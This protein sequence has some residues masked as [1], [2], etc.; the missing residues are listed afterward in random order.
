MIV[1]RPLFE[2]CLYPQSGWR[3]ELGAVQRSGSESA[4]QRG[5]GGDG[6]RVVGGLPQDNDPVRRTAH[7]GGRWCHEYLA[8]TSKV[9]SPRVCRPATLFFHERLCSLDRV[10]L[11][12]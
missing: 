11:T 3:G 9:E 7:A 10:C 6:A 4:K 2:T 1:P 8:S 5:G 12:P